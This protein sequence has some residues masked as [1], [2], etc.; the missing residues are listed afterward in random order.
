MKKLPD[1]IKVIRY[2]GGWFIHPDMWA[3]EWRCACG[4]HMGDYESAKRAR[5]AALYHVAICHGEE[6]SDD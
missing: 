1:W 6:E 5:A 2:Q 4:D 3:W